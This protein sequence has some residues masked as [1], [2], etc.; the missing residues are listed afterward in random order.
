MTVPPIKV[1]R[2]HND[3]SFGIHRPVF[4]FSQLFPT[5]SVS[6]ADTHSVATKSRL[7]S[8]LLTSRGYKEK[9]PQRETP[10]INSNSADQAD[11]RTRRITAQIELKTAY[12]NCI[13]YLHS[14]GGSGVAFSGSIPAI[15][16]SFDISAAAC[17]SPRRQIQVLACWIVQ[18]GDIQWFLIT[19]ASATCRKTVKSVGCKSRQGAPSKRQSTTEATTTRTDAACTTRVAG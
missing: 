7:F 8:R 17:A 11:A 2:E 3:C 12:Q 9:V 19:S 6:E 16:R 1:A 18:D 4:S 13:C 10:A 14:W 15:Q 5:Q